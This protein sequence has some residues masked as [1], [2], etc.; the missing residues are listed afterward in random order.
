ML[1]RVNV[2]EVMAEFGSTA[3]MGPL[4]LCGAKTRAGI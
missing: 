3:R 1:Q 4:Q 2:L